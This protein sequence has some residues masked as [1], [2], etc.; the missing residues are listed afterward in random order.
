MIC[1]QHATVYTP[2]EVIEDGMVLLA[3]GRIQAIA[4]SHQIELP[5]RVNCIDAT[6]LHLVPGFID[7]QLNGA[8]GLD[9]TSDP[10]S[11][12]AVADYLPQTGVTSFLPT[13]ITSPL[14]AV[15]AAQKVITN[16]PPKGF[17]GATPLGLHIEGPIFAPRQKGCAQS[18][19][20]A[21]AHRR[22]SR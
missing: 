13:I 2:D 9:F 14:T 6:G 12:W 3:D 19:P 22:K 4:P 16:G 21:A 10:G 1:I 15:A 11:I 7:L 17:Q 8:I 5:E 18:R 20:F